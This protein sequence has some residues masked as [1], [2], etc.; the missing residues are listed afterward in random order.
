MRR[1]ELMAANTQMAAH[2]AV[3]WRHVGWYNGQVRRT[4]DTDM[5]EDRVAKTLSY[6]DPLVFVDT[7]AATVT[8]RP[9]NSAV[10]QNRPTLVCMAAHNRDFAS[11]TG[12]PYGRW[13]RAY[14]DPSM[15]KKKVAK[16]ISM[17]YETKI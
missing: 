7:R 17:M 15:M 1:E 14:A 2:R 8:A 11:T 10:S 16:T 6:H 4:T 9:N 12:S 5:D 3:R 13:P